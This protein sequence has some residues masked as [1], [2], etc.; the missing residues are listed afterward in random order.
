[1]KPIT[2]IAAVCLM[3][4]AGAAVAADG[5]TNPTVK[6]RMDVMQAQRAAVGAL[7]GMASGQAAFDAEKAQAAKAALI[8]AARDIAPSSSRRK[9]I[10]SARP[11]PRSG[12]TGTIMS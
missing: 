4:A 3:F 8:A 11:S 2:K 9:T 1:M 10:R 7:G 5:V 12:R 6:A